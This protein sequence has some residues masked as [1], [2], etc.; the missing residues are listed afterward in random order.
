LKY[1]PVK[2][3]PPPRFRAG[4]LLF[5]KKADEKS[6]SSVS[7]ERIPSLKWGGEVDRRRVAMDPK[8]LNAIFMP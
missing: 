2:K 3:T 7:L 8:Y 1:P 5:Q 6:L 4:H